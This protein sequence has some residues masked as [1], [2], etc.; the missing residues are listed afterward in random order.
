MLV[1]SLVTRKNTNVLRKRQDCRYNKCGEFPVNS[2]D[3][4]DLST[5]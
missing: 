2:G 1:F 5:P 4:E 3:Y